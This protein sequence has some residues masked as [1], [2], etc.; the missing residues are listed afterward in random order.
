MLSVRRVVAFLVL[1]ALLSLIWPFGWNL[2]GM[3]QAGLGVVCAMTLFVMS[4]LTCRFWR[5][6]LARGDG[7]A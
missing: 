7:R 4:Y 1:G 6:A 2:T 3:M 5:K